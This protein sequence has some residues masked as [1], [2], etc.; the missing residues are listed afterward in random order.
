MEK[1]SIEKVCERTGS[2]IVDYG[3]GQR[4][5]FGL[6]SICMIEFGKGKEL[7]S[8]GSRKEMSLDKDKLYCVITRTDDMMD[9]LE[10]LEDVAIFFVGG[11]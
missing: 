2:I 8:S 4:E 11:V 9:I 5:K 1:E 7:F 6:S 3:G 10:P